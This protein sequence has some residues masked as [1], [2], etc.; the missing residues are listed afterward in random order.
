MTAASQW[1][2]VVMV[3]VQVTT[4]EYRS[5]DVT[6]MMKMSTLEVS[7]D[8]LTADSM[9]VIKAVGSPVLGRIAKT[10]QQKREA[11]TAAWAAARAKKG[12]EG[13]DVS[14]TSFEYA[15]ALESLGKLVVTSEPSGASVTVDGYR[16]P[17]STKAEGYADSG[18]RRI[19][20]ARGGQTVGVVCD[21]NKDGVTAVRVDL[22]SGGAEC[23]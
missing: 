12:P 10:D 15:G 1:F 3:A 7:D 18:K 11:A 9:L 4:M 5:S 17:Q 19:V 20:V 13:H 22:N 8:A 16:W 21:V 14:L 23:K 2:L 6:K